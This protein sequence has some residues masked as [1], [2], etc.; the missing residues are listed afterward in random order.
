[1][2]LEYEALSFGAKGLF[3][4]AKMLV[5]G[6]IMV[7]CDSPIHCLTFSSRICLSFSNCK[8][9]VNSWRWK[10]HIAILL[11]KYVSYMRSCF[12]FP[13]YSSFSFLQTKKG[14]NISG[15]HS[16][17]W[18]FDS[19][20]LSWTQIFS[21]NEETGDPS[22]RAQHV[23]VWDAGMLWIHGGF[24]GSSA[25]KLKQCCELF[26]WCVGRLFCDT[27]PPCATF[28]CET[29]DGSEILLTTWNV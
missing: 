16:D 11:T 4:G 14:L 26:F 27:A 12:V 9:A 23:G 25:R 1:M 19:H 6:L 18:K 13:S 29:V 8:S 21:V 10:I 2:E 28:F 20:S 5:S 3:S 24:D 17:T 15:L 22:P 7:W